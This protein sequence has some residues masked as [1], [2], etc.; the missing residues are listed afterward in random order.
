MP[1]Q[2][3]RDHVRHANVQR[4]ATLATP[5]AA[6]VLPLLA[7][8]CAHG[9][10]NSSNQTYPPKAESPVAAYAAEASVASAFA[11][12]PTRVIGRS[13]EGREITAVEI[14]DGD[15]LIVFIAGIHGN[16]PAG[17]P[18]TERLLVELKQQPALLEGRRIVAVARANPDGLYADDRLNVNGVDLNRNFPAANHNPERDR[19]GSMPLSE[20]EARALHDLFVSLPTPA[21]VISLHQPLVCVD[22]DGPEDRTRPL[23]EAL[24][25][26][27]GLPVKKLGSRP[28]SLG[29]WLGVDR[30]TPTITVEFYKADTA[31]SD[32]EL[33]ELY[34]EMMLAAVTYP[35]PLP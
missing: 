8:G 13:V 6:L 35:E 5:A 20:P 33:W 25:E 12:L 14:G 30:Q 27:S 26:A 29:S 24:A 18:L 23:A 9:P 17:V 4:M 2:R 16:E 31:R 22:Y 10:S 7:A 1:T 28:G 3:N 34:G 11:A 19:H 21:R 32:A 15:E